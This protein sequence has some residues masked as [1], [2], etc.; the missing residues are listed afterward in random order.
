MS[1]KSPTLICLF[2]AFAASP[3][4]IAEEQWDSGIAGHTTLGP[5]CPVQRIGDDRCNDR[6]YSATVSV[7]TPDRS[8]KVTEFT[9]DST[10]AFRVALP[11]GNYLLDSGTKNGMPYPHAIPKPVTVEPHTFTP[12]DVQFDTGMRR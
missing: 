12:V 4:A 2:A 8:Q 7:K 6:P 11:P 9:S 10:G 3:I 5:T 1:R